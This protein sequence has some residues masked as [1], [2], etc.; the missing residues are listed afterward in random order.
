MY[1]SYST[2]DRVVVADILR[3]PHRCH[4]LYVLR[5]YGT[6]MELEAL[7]A[8]IEGTRPP[9]RAPGLTTTG[10]VSSVQLHHTHLPKL[11][12]G[13]VL[14]YDSYEQRI[15]SLDDDRLD[16]LLEMGHR[17]LESLRRDRRTDD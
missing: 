17:I 3:N 16:S 5:R 13:G 1:D 10:A 4:I 6:P 11:D 14:R 2:S 8:H 12:G 7:A 9:T 15:V